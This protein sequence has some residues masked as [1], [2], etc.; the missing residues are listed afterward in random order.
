MK[1]K[2]QEK[3]KIHK[4]NNFEEFSKLKTAYLKIEAQFRKEINDGKL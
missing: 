4:F 3:K 2:G 1:N